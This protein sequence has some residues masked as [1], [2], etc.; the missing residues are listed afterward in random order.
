MI[1]LATRSPQTSEP[2]TT[3]APTM[4]YGIRRESCADPR[5]KKAPSAAI[6]GAS[7]TPLP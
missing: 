7:L 2:A 4:R 1:V 5:R 3:A 6:F